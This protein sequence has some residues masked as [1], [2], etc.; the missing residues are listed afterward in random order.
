MKAAIKLFLASTVV[1]AT[2]ASAAL[3]YATTGTATGNSFADAL[4]NAEQVAQARCQA[5]GLGGAGNL[6]MTDSRPLGLLW[7]VSVAGN[8][9]GSLAI[10]Q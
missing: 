6:R 1:V 5:A 3:P 9:G 2:A 8:C 4:F 7:Q 10:R